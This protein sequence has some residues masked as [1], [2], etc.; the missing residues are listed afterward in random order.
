MTYDPAAALL[1]S[2]LRDVLPPEAAFE[3]AATERLLAVFGRSGYEQVSPPLV[4]FE[5]SL[6][7][8]VGAA[9]TR[10]TFRLMDPVSQRMMAV[11]SDMTPQMA[12]IA[13]TRL[14]GAPRPLRLSYAGTVLR[15]TAGQ[16]RPERQF[17]QA[18]AE[19]IGSAS[20]AADAEVI[21]LATE[22]LTALGVRD[23]T[24]DLTMPTLVPAVCAALGLRPD[25]LSRLEAALDRKD[26]A[27]VAEIAGS[28]ARALLLA[29]IDVAGPAETTLDR[30]AALDLPPR[31]RAAVDQLAEVVR[32]LGPARDG[33]RLTVDAVEHRGFEY[34]DGTSF[35]LSAAGIRSELG[36]GGRYRVGANGRAASGEPATGFTLYMDVVLR[37]VPRPAH[38]R[39]LY[40]P[41]EIAPEARRHWQ[42]S[43]WI[44]VAALEPAD[45]AA[46]EAA[47]LGCDHMLVDGVPVD[48][49]NL[50]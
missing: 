38:P 39:R 15:V 27:L 26:A 2:G 24:V 1:P 50:S 16:L 22:A 33:L 17:R 14:A 11:R 19:L 41:P 46:A 5:D 37:A 6:L 18:G 44:T 47:R 25:R 4:E 21:L 34:H 10:E 35:S 7:S 3:A 23:V 31:A 43:G 9:M 29:L 36:R 45:D 32:R 40:L 8:G 12:R 49:R 42:E 20:A 13:T 28:R 30:L 48:V